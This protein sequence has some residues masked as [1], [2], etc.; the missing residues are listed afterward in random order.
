MAASTITLACILL[1]ENSPFE[2]SI[3]PS[4]SVYSLKKTIRAELSRKLSEIAA[5]NLEL[6]KVDIP[7]EARASITDD[8]LKEADVMGALDKISEYFQEPTAKEHIHV[9]VRRPQVLQPANLRGQEVA[10]TT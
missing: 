3:D 9:V 2:V 4:S 7:Y 5:M 1:G 10:Y 8:S 6:W